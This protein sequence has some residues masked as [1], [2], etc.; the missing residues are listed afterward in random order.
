MVK[1]QKK[2][3]EGQDGPYRPGEGQG[4]ERQ[5]PARP[6]QGNPDDPTP[7]RRIDDPD[8][9]GQGRPDDDQEEDQDVQR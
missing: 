3:R 6:G 9:P 1:E 8:R 4:Q 2:D 5:A 7:R